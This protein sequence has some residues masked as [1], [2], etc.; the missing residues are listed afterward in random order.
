MDARPSSR[1]HHSPPLQ[2]TFATDRGGIMHVIGRL[3]ILALFAVS[4]AARAD[5]VCRQIDIPGATNTQVWQINNSGQAAATSD[6]GGA[7][8]SGG[9]WLPLPTPPASSGYTAANLGALGINDSGMIA[10]NALSADGLTEQGYTLS[11]D[12][13]AFFSHPIPGGSRTEPRAI[14][15]SGIVTGWSFDD[16]T[17]GPAWV[18]NPNGAAGYPAGFTDIVPTLSGAAAIRVIPGAMNAAGQFVGSADFAGRSRRAFVYD[19]SAAS[20]FTLFQVGG[21]FTA[22]RGINDNGA[23]TGFTA[24]PG[25]NELIGFLLTSA[26][27]ETF[28]CPE[29]SA[30]LLAPESINNS[31]LISGNYTDAAGLFH[32]FIAY[33]NV[34]LPVTSTNGA[35]VFDAAVAPNT[36]V[37][38]DPAPAA[39]Y[40]FAIGSGN[41]LFASATLPIGIGDNLY[42]VIAQGHGFTVAGGEKLDFTRNGFAGGVASFEVLGIEPSANLD[43]TSPT[44]FVTEA[45]FATAGRFTGTMTPMTIG[46][47]LADL[48]AN[49][50][51]VG[52]GKSLAAK[53]RTATSFY[54]TGDVTDTCAVLA[55][56]VSEVAAQSGKKLTASLAGALTA[57]AQSIVGA[58][59]CK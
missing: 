43:P 17:L 4:A 54:A 8:Y 42:T 21:L 37:F 51:G 46:D 12:A 31:D 48:E 24:K 3:G 41:P 45:S 23:V 15:N 26:G 14:S 20:P 39:G 59:G 47:E 40:R 57:E 49:A 19:P 1:V 5:Y 44:A 10:G 36:P 6:S 55:D 7:I 38:L 22:A 25:T 27:V 58:I 30:T 29:L 33:P 56:F 9:T 18:Y 52:P 34:V 11:G 35:F 13:Y 28:T 2:L 50:A 16:S 32:G 53:A